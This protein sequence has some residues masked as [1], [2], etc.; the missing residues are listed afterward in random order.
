MDSDLINLLCGNNNIYSEI[1]EW[2]R[3]DIDGRIS[4]N[5]CIIVAGNSCIGKTYSINKIC[6]ALNMYK[7]DINSFNCY[8]ST[9]FKDIIYKSSSSSLIQNL[10]NLSKK[11]VIV[12]D[13]FDTLFSAD[14]TLNQTL[15]KIL[16][17]Q[18]YKNILIICITN[19]SI[20]KKLGDI[21]KLC[22]IYELSSPT[23]YDVIKTLEYMK[24]DKRR[25]DLILS[26]YNGNINNVFESIKN[27]ELI[28]YNKVDEIYDVKHLYSANFNRH[29]V[30]NILNCDSWLIPLRYHENLIDELD[31]RKMSLTNKNEFYNNYIKIFC[32]FD[33]LMFK[34]NIEIALD[35]FACMVYKLSSIKSK[36]GIEHN[37]DKFTKILSYL[38]LQ[39][40]Y[41]KNSYN[42]DFPLYQI[43]N[44]HISF[45]HRKFIYFN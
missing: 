19:I 31:N 40:K 27:I 39:K 21:K 34:D 12:V 26:N 17:E 4:Y 2:L 24:I 13:N 18:K 16:T 35:L 11:K 45:L 25:I 8:N 1:L 41:I 29:I 38:S 10:E 33:K 23:K 42:N 6:E 15:V 9:Q 14:K 20:L 44:Y 28:E 36:K 37:M 3:R 22:K 7:I 30:I 5:S 43:G 32:D